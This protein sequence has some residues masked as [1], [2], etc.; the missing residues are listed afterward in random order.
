MVGSIDTVSTSSGVSPQ[1]YVA[2]TSTSGSTSFS[3]TL[4]AASGSSSTTTLLS[5]QKIIQDPAAGFITQYLSANGSQ[6]VSQSPSVITVAY[7][8][9][10]LT[11]EGTRKPSP[12][13]Q[14]GVT[15]TA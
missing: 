8:R 11:A 4:A 9:L 3:S 12:D 10:G 13:Q 2:H 5:H 7:L 14:Q 15:T 6:V 1:A